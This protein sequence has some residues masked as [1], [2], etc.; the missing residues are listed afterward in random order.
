MSN[1]NLNVKRDGKDLTEIN[2]KRPDIKKKKAP[3]PEDY[4]PESL[5]EQKAQTMRVSKTEGVLKSIKTGITTNFTAPFGLALGLSPSYVAFLT[6]IPHLLG[7]LSSLFVEALIRWV[8]KRKKVMVAASYMESYTWLLVVVLAILSLKNPW[9]LIILVTLDAVFMNLQYPI[10]NSIM[11]ETVPEN[12]LGKYFG[13]RNVL[14]GI[15]SLTSMIIA[16][17]ILNKFA[18]VNKLLGFAII[19]GAAF[20]ATYAATRYQSKI[21]DPYPKVKSKD[22]TKHSFAEFI[23]TIKENNFGRYTWFYATF[24]MVV[25]IA[26]PF[27]AIYMLEVLKF[28]YVTFT[29]VTLAAALSSLAS[30]KIWGKLI[31]KYGSKKIMSITSFLVPG[32]ALLWLISSDWRYLVCVEIYSGIVWA[33]FNLSCSTF[34]YESVKPEYKIKYYSY[35]KVLYGTG[36]FIGVMLGVLLVN[37]PPILFASNI[38]F[39]ILVSGTL[40]LLVAIIFIPKIQEEKVVSIDF[41]KGGFFNNF[42][43][44]RPRGG[45]TLEAVGPIQAHISSSDQK[46]K[47]SKRIN[48]I[49]KNKAKMG[50]N[51]KADKTKPTK[52]T[53]NEKK[54]NK[55]TPKRNMGD[56][57]SLASDKSRIYNNPSKPPRK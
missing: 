44:L 30:M 11:S 39:I 33:G 21:I 43:T 10:W 20:I 45:A 23:L 8:E 27:F 7:S 1:I 3:E 28:N 29:I 52:E 15:A 38:Q 55:S 2:V 48:K 19:F 51:Q 6:S 34:M 22:E 37:M 41:K 54:Q 35:N 9:L 5:T 36:V 25:N 56:N 4:T 53:I 13:L 31:D 32:G 50:I 26:T 57:K 17:L 46:V 49:E 16:G 14:V 12:R 47:E 18:D 42:I 40:R 24:Q